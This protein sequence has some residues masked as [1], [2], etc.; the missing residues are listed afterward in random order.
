MRIYQQNKFGKREHAVHAEGA[1][2]LIE[3]LVVIAI[4][5]ILAAMLLPALAR[6]KEKGKS[7]SCL[8]N[9]RQLSMASQ[10][11]L[12]DS[13][14]TF[15]P[16]YGVN[17]VT[18]V[19]I[20]DRW[21]DKFFDYYGKNLQLLLCPDEITNNLTITPGSDTNSADDAPRSYFI[22]GWNDVFASA[23]SDSLGLNGGDQMKE[24]LIVHPSNTLLF[25]EKTARAADYYMDLNEG[26]AGNDFEGIL[27]QSSHD[28]AP[29]DRAQG[30]GSG[31]SNYAV[32]DGSATFIR[33]PRGLQPLN[34]WAN[35]DV[36][37]QNYAASY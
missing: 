14:G 36:N 17:P 7:I 6:A 5:A 11:Y 12:G 15:P 33:F 19:N 35:S 20:T 3:L 21:P 28:S 37:R 27:D 1:F 31:G 18:G 22:N 24:I 10:M 32:T 2:T 23:P 29:G 16:R 8:N 13:Q 34:L 25:G 9:V 30:I 26:V 4:I